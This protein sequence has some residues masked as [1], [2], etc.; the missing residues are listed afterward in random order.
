MSPSTTGA[1]RIP[2]ADPQAAAEKTHD[3][4]IVGAGILGPA[5]A[6][7][8]AKSGR[9]VLLLDR[10]LSEPDRI[11]GELLQPGGCLALQ[12]LGIDDAL[13]GI[14]A[15]PCE[16]YQVFWGDQSVPIPYPEESKTMRW[17]DGSDAKKQE[18][19]SFHHGAFVQ[20]LRRKAQAVEGISLVEA[21]VNELLENE[22]G[23]IVGVK[24]TPR[25]SDDGAEQTPLDYRAKLT[26]VADGCMSKFR[27]ALLPSHVTPITR[28]HF[29][30]LVLEDADLPSPRHGHV[31]LGKRDLAAPATDNSVE[32]NPDAPS[33]GPVLVYQL[34]THETRMLVDIRG[35]KLP[36]QRDLAAFLREHVAPVL[37]KPIVPSF[38][39]ALDKA[40]S[41]DKAY[42]L[43]S[44]PNSY[45]PPYP[46][47]RDAKGAFLAGDSLNMRHPLTGGGMTVAFND[48][49][50]LTQLLGGGEPVHDVHG[51]ER[52]PVDL[53]QWSDVTERLEE[54]HWK[55]KNVASCI[56]VLSMALYSLFGADDENLEVLK[57]GCFKYF[58]LGGD[59]IQGPVSLLS[60]L[61]P[62]PS[63][64]FYHFFRVAFYSIYCLFT[65][66]LASRSPGHK[67]PV[68]QY[69]E[70]TL[71]SFKVF[72]TACLVFLPVLWGEVQM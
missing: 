56:N 60:A 22:E 31:I 5:L 43:R 64:L 38:E 27:R 30:G 9:S 69:P 68:W 8:L 49:V 66:P 35:S 17:S 26:I 23:T 45:L 25:K 39:T 40:L 53:E 14:D 54:W 11:V 21:T 13:D 7:G 46:Q 15:V 20:S 51:D 47:G 44:M 10:D 12:R 70:L 57:T 24:A 71:R 33:L 6:Y 48:A 4:A 61:K 29:V 59:C 19:R 3:V 16:G 1:P 63:L 37:P 50:L 62:S 34:A 18:G 28:S 52:G 58:E 42:R 65:S 41:G 67:P 55:R 72:W 2:S 32:E 36:P